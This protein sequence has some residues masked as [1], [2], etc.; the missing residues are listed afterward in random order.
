LA[1]CTW[2]EFHSDPGSVLFQDDFSRPSSGWDRY[3]EQAYL[4]DYV[5]GAYRIQISQP[6]RDAWATPA[7]EFGDVRIEVDAA[8]SG[9]PDNNLFG[10]LCRYQDAHNFYFFVVSSDG[11]AGIG[12]RQNGEAILL[13]SDSM[14]PRD[15]VLQGQASNHLRADCVGDLLS[16]YVNGIPA[17]EAR[18]GEWATGGVGLIAGSYTEPGVVIDFDNFSVL[19]P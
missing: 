7:L 11:Y 1:S 13:S 6:E 14:L 18:G 15:S 17:A 3:Q 9:G 10:V 19:Q 5:G 2:F 16:L 8:K 12:M 4:S